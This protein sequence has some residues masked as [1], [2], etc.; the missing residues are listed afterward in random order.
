MLK[1]DLPSCRIGLAFK[2]KPHAQPKFDAKLCKRFLNGVT[3][4]EIY[5][6]HELGG[7]E[8]S[9]LATVGKG[10]CKF[11]DP[12]V[13]ALGRKQA[14]TSALRKRG[15]G[16]HLFGREERHLIW[17]AYWKMV[18]TQAK[19]MPVPPET[20]PT[21]VAAPIPIHIAGTPLTVPQPTVH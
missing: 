5:V 15:Q 18:E 4:C 9:T 16:R 19:T 11:P 1:I 8:Q 6:L 14:L 12:F 17:T 13:K 20:P 21:P 3:E 7:V 10:L 2:H